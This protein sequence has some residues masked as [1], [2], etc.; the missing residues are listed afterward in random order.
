MCRS[1]KL[2]IVALFGTIAAVLA[3][4]VSDLCTME[5]IDTYERRVVAAW[6]YSDSDEIPGRYLIQTRRRFLGV[7]RV[8]R[9]SRRHL[10]HDSCAPGVDAHA[11]TGD[12]MKDDVFSFFLGSMVTL[13][14]AALAFCIY[15]GRPALTIVE[16]R[17]VTEVRQET[18]GDY[19]VID[20][21]KK[22]WRMDLCRNQV[23]S[24]GDKFRVGT[25]VDRLGFSHS[26][27]VLR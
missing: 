12:A 11:T 18:R 21:E 6:R 27:E 25:N 3:L 9:D 17:T 2:G 19:W 5:T 10:G 1:E 23:Y 24:V 20:E 15:A 22:A 26:P 8:S 13:V 7:G 16:E 4:G 14:A